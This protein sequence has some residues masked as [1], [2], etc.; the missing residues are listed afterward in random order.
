MCRGT[1][2]LYPQDGVAGESVGGRVGARW[3]GGEAVLGQPGHVLPG[4][5]QGLQEDCHLGRLQSARGE[6]PQE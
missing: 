5:L 1:Q 6:G 3:A 2:R 4:P